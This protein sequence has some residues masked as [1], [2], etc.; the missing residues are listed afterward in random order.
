MQEEQPLQVRKLTI[1]QNPM[2]K[3]RNDPSA[4]RTTNETIARGKETLTIYTRRRRRRTKVARCTK[5][6]DANTDEAKYV[7]N[8][9]QIAKVRAADRETNENDVVCHRCEC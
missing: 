8:V 4:E 6:I 1:V 7:I 5:I 2:E 9:K 3:H